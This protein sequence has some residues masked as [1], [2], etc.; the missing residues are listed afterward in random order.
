MAGGLHEGSWGCCWLRSICWSRREG[1]KS[2]LY[3]RSQ[4]NLKVTSAALGPSPLPVFRVQKECPTTISSHPSRS[5]LPRGTPEI[6]R[7]RKGLDQVWGNFPDWSH[8]VSTF[9]TAALRQS[10][11]GQDRGKSGN[12]GGGELPLDLSSSLD[13]QAFVRATCLR[14]KSFSR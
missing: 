9:R 7:V 8:A 4:S 5:K 2:L 3:A 14:L 13:P 1:K 6:P 11:H 12:Q 10:F